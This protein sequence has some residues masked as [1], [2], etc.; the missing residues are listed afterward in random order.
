MKKRT[1]YYF[2]GIIK[3]EYFDFDSI[4]IDKKS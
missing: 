3:L 4:L 1:Y 2:N